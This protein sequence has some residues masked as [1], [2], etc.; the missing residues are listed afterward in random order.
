MGSIQEWGFLRFRKLSCFESRRNNKNSFNLQSV[1][2]G[3]NIHV[4]DLCTSPAVVGCDESFETLD[5]YQ[6]FTIGHPFPSD[7]YWFVN[8]YN[9]SGSIIQTNNITIT[10]IEYSIENDLITTGGTYSISF[11]SMTTSQII[12]I[13]MLRES[14]HMINPL[15]A[16]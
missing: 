7:C 14:L 5:E 13:S 15:A 10:N 11:S 9:P 12:I 4:Y 2:S 3:C 1:N 16:L 6:Y 8:V